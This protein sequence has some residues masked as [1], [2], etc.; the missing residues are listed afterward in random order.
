MVEYSD[1]NRIENTAAHGLYLHP[2]DYIVRTSR[3]LHPLSAILPLR[4]E[5]LTLQDRRKK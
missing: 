2:R 4:R 3:C 1:D 5:L